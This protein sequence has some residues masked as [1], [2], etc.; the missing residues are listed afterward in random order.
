GSKYTLTDAVLNIFDAS[1]D[2]SVSDEDA[3]KMITF[4]TK[5]SFSIFRNS[6]RLAIEKRN[7]LTGS[8]TIFF[9]LSKMNELPYQFRF[10]ANNFNP[11]VQAYLEDKYLG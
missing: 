8:D 7:D 11:A 9:T 4:N 2:N 10:T 6:T 5:E 1:F 3:K